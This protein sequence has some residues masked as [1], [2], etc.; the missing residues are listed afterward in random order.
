MKKL[1]QGAQRLLCLP[2][3]IEAMDNFTT[4]WQEHQHIS[5]LVHH[6]VLNDLSMNCCDHHCLHRAHT[7]TGLGGVRVGALPVVS[8]LY[9]VTR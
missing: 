2:T 3:T 1:G 4:H 6:S 8:L 5:L 9:N 7:S